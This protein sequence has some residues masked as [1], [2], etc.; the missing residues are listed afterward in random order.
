MCGTTKIFFL[1]ESIEKGNAESLSV[2][3]DHGCENDKLPPDPELVWDLL[4]HLDPHESMG[5]HG[6]YPE[7]L[8]ELVAVIVRSLLM[9]LEW[10]WASEEIPVDWKLSNFQE[11]ARRLTLETIGLSVSVQCLVK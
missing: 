1:N 10:S 6:I 11:R 4:L 2:L 7:V 3:R 8:K 5:P 9:I